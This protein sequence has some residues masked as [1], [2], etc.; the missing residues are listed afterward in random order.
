MQ[1]RRVG[2]QVGCSR[3]VGLDV[4]FKSG[5]VHLSLS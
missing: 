1:G 5:F 2:G 3:S 4:N